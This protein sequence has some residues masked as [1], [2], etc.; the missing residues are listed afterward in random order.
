MAEAADEESLRSSFYEAGNVAT[1]LHIVN[2][3]SG[4][5]IIP[6]LHIPMLRPEHRAHLR[7]LVGPTPTRQVSLYVRQDYVREAL[8]NIV[9]DG[10]KQI[11]PPRMI[12]DHLA[13]YPIRL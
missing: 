7:R 9:A 13:H 2:E 5:T 12:D 10:L 11:I 1:L 4:F 6:E 3:N 8:L